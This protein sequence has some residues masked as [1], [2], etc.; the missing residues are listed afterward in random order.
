M[1]KLSEDQAK[2]IAKS[3]T[4]EEFIVAKDLL[5]FHNKKLG[6]FNSFLV[7]MWMAY[8][9]EDCGL[10][11][12][13]VEEAEH[14]TIGNMLLEYLYEFIGTTWHGASKNFNDNVQKIYE[15]VRSQD[16]VQ[17]IYEA[18]RSWFSPC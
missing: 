8:C 9:H 18:V 12:K 17:K 2:A 11:C 4:Y 14:V 3:K 5:G 13:L 1:A 7:L 6:Q 15:A 10:A 16:N